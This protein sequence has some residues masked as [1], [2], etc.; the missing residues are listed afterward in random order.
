VLFVFKLLLSLA[1]PVAV[2]IFFQPVSLAHTLA[3]FDWIAIDIR[4]IV[5]ESLLLVLNLAIFAVIALVCLRIIRP[6]DADD[7]ALLNQVPRWLRTA[8]LPFASGRGK[9]AQAT[10]SPAPAT[11]DHNDDSR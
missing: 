11:S 3:S 5:E 4:P 7:I 10:A 9:L 2:T 6:L 8:L 1:V